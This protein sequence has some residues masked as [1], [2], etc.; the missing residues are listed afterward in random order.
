M[1]EHAIEFLQGWIGEKVH[2][3]SSQ[4]RIDKQAETLAKECAA[5]AAEVGIPLEDIQEE[6]GDIQELIASRLEEAAEAEESQ[7]A[8]GKAAE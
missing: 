1:S 8:P 2:C 7:Q 5:E 4:A 6:V 3:Q